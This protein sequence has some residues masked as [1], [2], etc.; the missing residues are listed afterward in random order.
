MSLNAWDSVKWNRRSL[1]LGT[2]VWLL[3]ALA[4]LRRWLPLDVPGALLLL[5]IFVVTPLVMGLVVLRAEQ[6]DYNWLYR[7]AAL[8]QPL[9]AIMVG[10]SLL[11]ATGPFAAVLVAPW[12]GFTA[13]LALIG[14]CRLI[15][16][17]GL[18]DLCLSMALVYLPIGGVWLVLARLGA[19]PLGFSHTLVGLT[20]IHFHFVTLAALVLTGL[21]G[22]QI[23]R[24]SRLAH[25]AYC[26]AAV[27][28]LAGPLL[29]AAGHT[30]TQVMGV[31]LLESVASLMLALS[32]LLVAVLSLGVVVPTANPPVARLL[33][34]I[35]GMSVLGAMVIA[36][37]FVLGAATGAWS[38]SISTMEATHGLLN[39]LGF[40]LCGLV[41]WWLTRGRM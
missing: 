12:L 41:G 8:L 32:L 11:L 1:G 23:G 29:V 18:P 26:L 22:Q 16:E 7:S 10:A 28:M 13:L 9:A 31:H 19:R 21:I 38:I 34:A 37:I 17:H 33:L 5:A 6:R 3:T 20:A 27:G 24:A 36:S 39:A 15:Q 30:L 2:T 14:I 25:P 40:G 4:S 35:S